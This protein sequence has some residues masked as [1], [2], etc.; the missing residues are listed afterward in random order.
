VEHIILYPRDWLFNSSVMGFLIVF[1]HGNEEEAPQ[2]I[3]DDENANLYTYYRLR[4]EVPRWIRDDGT[5]VL[6]LDIFKEKKLFAGKEIPK[7]LLRYMNYNYVNRNT[8]KK[9]EK[10]DVQREHAEK[11][12]YE[13]FFT[14]LF[15][16]SKQ[17]PCKNLVNL[18]NKPEERKEGFIEFVGDLPQLLNGEKLGRC[19]LCGGETLVRVDSQRY[20]LPKRIFEFDLMHHS[21]LGASRGEFPNSM[22]NTGKTFPICP[23]CVYLIIHSHVAWTKLSDSTS[24]FINAP[25]FKVMWHLNKYAKELYG[26]GKVEG[27]KELF[28]MSLIELALK[29]NLQL[30]KWTMMNIEVVIKHKDKKDKLEFFFI[31]HEIVVL[32]LDK[33]VASLLFDIGRTEVLSWFLDGEFDKILNEG[34]KLF[35]KALMSSDSNT[36]SYSQKLFELYALVNEKRKGGAL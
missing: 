22:W 35:R 27:V 1:F 3:R 34:E 9:G 4:E 14:S 23:L 16:N 32:L 33:S 13:Y 6:N 26:A 15:S 12:V 29:L 11:E 30:G 5:V 21:D 18:G 8:K 36:L 17:S 7:P 19:G 31:P 20:M 28:G 2:W 25:S 10:Q 24:I